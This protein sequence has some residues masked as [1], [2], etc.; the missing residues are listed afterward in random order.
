MR[1]PKKLPGPTVSQ[2][3]TKEYGEDS[4]AI[5]S[6]AVKKGDRVLVVD[7]IIATGRSTFALR[8]G[9]ADVNRTVLME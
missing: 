3:F 6:D 1:K 8:G 2:T 4:F 5:Q 7:D 9:I